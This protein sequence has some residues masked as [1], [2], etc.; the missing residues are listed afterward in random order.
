[1]GASQYCRVPER[2]TVLP[3]SQWKMLSTKKK[4]KVAS[5]SEMVVSIFKI[6]W[7][8]MPEDSKPYM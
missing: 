1:M 5:F 7:F 8:L 4:I 2:N 6:T 3:Q